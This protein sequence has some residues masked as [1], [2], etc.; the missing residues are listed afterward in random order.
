MSISKKVVL[1]IKEQDYIATLDH[2]LIFYVNDTIRLHFQ[3]KQFGNMQ[4]AHRTNL[5]RVTFYP[6]NGLTAQVLVETSQGV[7]YIDDTVVNETNSTI[8]FNLKPKHTRF[9]G[10]GRMQ[11]RLMD[12]EGERDSLKCDFK[13]PAIQFEIRPSINEALDESVLADIVYVVLTDENDN[14]ITNENGFMLVL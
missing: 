6:L 5:N 12:S 9:A 8:E 10:S 2:P 7:D 13:L 1:T 14:P 3:I 11:I 4:N